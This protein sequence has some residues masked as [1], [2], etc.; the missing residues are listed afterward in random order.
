MVAAVASRAEAQEFE[1]G[2]NDPRIISPAGLGP[3]YSG[4]LGAGVGLLSKKPNFGVMTGEFVLQPRFFLEGEYRSNFFRVDTRNADP[5]GVFSLHIRP[6]VALFNPDYDTVA[7]S[8]GLDLDV[9]VPVSDSAAADQTNVG[10]RA[11]ISAAFFPKKAFTLTLHEV[12]ER[13]LFMRPTVVTNANQNH[14]IVGADASL[15]PGGRALD[16]TLGYA[17]DI[18]RYDDLDRIDTDQHDLRFLASWRFYPMTYLF[19]EWTLQPTTYTSRPVA[20]DG[21]VGNFTD[22]TP[23]KAYAG[24]SGY[25]TDRLGVL[26]RAGYGNTFLDDTVPGTEQF[27]SFIGQ[28]QVSWRFGASSIVHLGFARDFD[29]SPLGG[30]VEYLRPYAAFTMRLS[31]LVDLNLDFAYDLRSYGAWT[32]LALSNGDLPTASDPHRSEN[33]IRAG[34]LLDFDITRVLGA[35]IGYRYESIVSDYEV[36]TNGVQNFIGYDD[37]R[38]FA[39]LNLRY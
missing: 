1:Q 35:T 29:V 26:V 36:T 7:L 31:E 6:G 37:H 33:V 13:T 17:Y 16:F 38:V 18:I 3:R 19:L 2:W 4:L 23:F 12:F 25:I 15:H 14:N 10:G 11:H 24:L 22:G 8:V 32:P 9:F 39:S 30:Y 20:A 28:L 21:G 27:S 5:D 34:A